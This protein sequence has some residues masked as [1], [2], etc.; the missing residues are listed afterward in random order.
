[1]QIAKGQLIY[2]SITLIQVC[3]NSTKSQT[4]FF[5][6]FYL[7]FQLKTKRQPKCSPVFKIV[8]FYLAL[9]QVSHA[10]NFQGRHTWSFA[11]V[12][13]KAF[14]LLYCLCVS[15][16][17]RWW[18]LTPLQTLLI[19]VVFIFSHMFDLSQNE[20]EGSMTGVSERRGEVSM[21]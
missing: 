6:Y 3:S 12:H 10:S 18:W 17:C 8:H 14:P 15:A 13:Y 1:M 2:D 16:K 4:S 21:G 5:R 11:V 20:N 7:C 19:L 9:F